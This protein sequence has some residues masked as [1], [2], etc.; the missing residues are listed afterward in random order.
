MSELVA[1]LAEIIKKC[2]RCGYCM[3]ECPAYGATKIEWDVARG[4]NWLASE[5]VN[6]TINLDDDLDEPIDTCLRCGRCSE[7]CPSKVDTPKAVQLIRTIRYRAGR[8]KLPYRMLF[9]QIMPYPKRMAMGSHFMSIVQ[10]VTPDGWLN[11]GIVARC[12]PPV[13]SMPKLPK[14]RAR[15]I[16]SVNNKAVGAKR[17]K[18]LYFMGCSTDLVFPEVAEATV[19]LLTSQ[20]IDVI[21]PDVS[22]CGLPAYS[23]GHIDGALRL[24]ARNLESLNFNEVDAVVSDC[25]TCVS[26]LNEYKDLP[27]DASLKEKAS[28]LFNKVQNLPDYLLSVGLLAPKQAV[29]KVVTYHQPCHFARSLGAA[30]SVEKI[31]K[32]LPG[33]EFRKAE[34]QNTCCGGAGSYCFSQVGRSQKIL[35]N[36]MEGIVKTNSDTLVTNC[37]GCMMQLQTG[38]RQLEASHSQ[39]IHLTNFANLLSSIYNES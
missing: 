39:P 25:P 24:A 27:L 15:N 33:V 37:P 5:L 20:G 7:N 14:K 31:L 21:I 8:M 35:I 29:K 3:A 38:L 28:A 2:S 26:F 13:Q 16:V 11:N 36:K 6:G 34:N 23:Y 19:N 17:G 12:C 10:S 4:R 1:E 32:N 9:E 30:N 18:V 22:C